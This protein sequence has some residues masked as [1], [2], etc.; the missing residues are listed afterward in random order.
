M[1]ADFWS[2]DPAIVMGAHGQAQRMGDNHEVEV[3]CMLGV[4]TEAV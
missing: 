4:H 3:G 1:Q 2:I